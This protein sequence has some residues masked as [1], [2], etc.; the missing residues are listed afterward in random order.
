MRGVS[1]NMRTGHLALAHTRTHAH[2]IW[3]VPVLS[4]IK[5]EKYDGVVK[6]VR[7]HTSQCSTARELENERERERERERELEF[8]GL[9]A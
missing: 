3:H 1:Y 4:M 9:R 8:R 6:R 5:M 2:D 7:G